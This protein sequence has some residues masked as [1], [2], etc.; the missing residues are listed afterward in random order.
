MD[1]INTCYG[2]IDANIMK[3]LSK[4]KLL[5]FDVD[6]TITEGGVYLDNTGLEFKKFYTKDGYGLHH[7]NKSGVYCA[8]ITGR[9]AELTSRRMQEIGIELLIQ[10]E[11]DKKTALTKLCNKLSIDLEN[12]V[13]IGDD[14]NDLS[15]FKIAGV[16]ACPAD[17]HPYI[18]KISDLIMTK[19]GGFGAVRELCDLIMMAQGKLNLDGGPIE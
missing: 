2:F 19:K 6:G 11:W 5:A 7:L 14:L 9:K 10:G 13:T 12:T 15:M 17:A 1:K 8:A 3:R 18:L 16:T 4:I